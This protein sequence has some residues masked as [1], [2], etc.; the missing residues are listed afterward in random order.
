MLTRR[1]LITAGVA[2]GLSPHAAA[3]VHA[4]PPPVNVEQSQTEALREISRAV[5]SIDRTLDQAWLSN[6]T[7]FG[8]VA[9]VRAQCDTYFRTN[10]RFPDAVDVGLGVFNQVYD[11]HIKYQQQLMI[12]RGPDARYWIRYM[13]TT[14]VLRGEQD[15]G[16][17]GVPYDRA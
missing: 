9:K 10:L 16:Y 11:W 5:E 12:N 13:F 4:A 8:L 7:A 3:P 14:L 6:D 15:A 17:V 2:G 1:E